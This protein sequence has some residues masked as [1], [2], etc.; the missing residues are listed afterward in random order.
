MIERLRDFQANC[1]EKV[2]RILVYRDGVGDDFA[3]KVTVV[4][5]L[6]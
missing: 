5:E 1:K 4:F 2:R 6:F 3:D